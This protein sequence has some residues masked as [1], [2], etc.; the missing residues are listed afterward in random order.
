M[1][2]KVIMMMVCTGLVGSGDNGNKGRNDGCDSG[3]VRSQ[4]PLHTH[5]QG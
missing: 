5:R 1:V 4:A 2:V 3:D